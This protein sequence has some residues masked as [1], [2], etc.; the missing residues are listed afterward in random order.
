MQVSLLKHFNYHL[1]PHLST[2]SEG[3]KCQCFVFNA[4]HGSKASISHHRCSRRN[5]RLPPKFTWIM[6]GRQRDATGGWS[7]RKRHVSDQLS[8]RGSSRARNLSRQLMIGN[9]EYI[10]FC[11]ALKSRYRR[12]IRMIFKWVPQ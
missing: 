3:S 4:F 2:Y 10:D 6:D 12:C 5:R 7:S 11:K 9:M 1:N 8:R